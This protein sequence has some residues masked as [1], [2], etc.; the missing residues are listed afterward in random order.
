MKFRHFGLTLLAA[1][2]MPNMA[3][4]QF[5]DSFNFLKSIR[6]RSEDGKKAMDLLSKPGTVIIDTRDSSSGEA[7]LHIVTR[8]KD[9]PWLNF[10]LQKGAKPDILDGQGNSPL[11]IA[12][13]GRFVEGAALLLQRKAQVNLAN[14]SGETP[15]IRAVQMRDPFM[16]RLLLAGGANPDKADTMAGLSARDYAKR[17]SRGAAIL[18]LIEETKAKSATVTG[19]KL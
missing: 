11:M 1:T 12:V 10:L 5:S 13:Q 7:A 4:A 18:K 2:L 14:K 3:S 9:L 6:S 16:V 17:D 8:D 19:P 15:L